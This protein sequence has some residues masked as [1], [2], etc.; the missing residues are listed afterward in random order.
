MKDKEIARELKNLKECF[1]ELALT[2]V[3]KEDQEE[4]K[5]HGINDNSYNML[6]AFKTLQRALNGD[7]KALKI[8][9]EL[10]GQDKEMELKEQEINIKKNMLAVKVAEFKNDT[11]FYKDTTL[12]SVLREIE[13]SNIDE[14]EKIENKQLDELYS[15]SP[16][17]DSIPV[18]ADE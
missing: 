5:A 1:K 16:F 4:L 15:F 10:T 12:T 18:I 9:L 2:E 8:F 7:M 3:R 14:R 11:N 6:I 17:S 13:T